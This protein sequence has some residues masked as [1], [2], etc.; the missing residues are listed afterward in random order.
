MAPTMPRLLFDFG[1]SLDM[2]RSLRP[3][4]VAEPGDTVLVPGGCVDF[5]RATVLAHLERAG[6]FS[7]RSVSVMPIPK[8]GFDVRDYSGRLVDPGNWSQNW[9]GRHED[10]V[11]LVLQL[12]KF[13]S[14]RESLIAEYGPRPETRC[15][16]GAFSGTFIASSYWDSLRFFRE[17]N[18]AAL[19]AVPATWEFGVAPALAPLCQYLRS[20]GLQ[21][22]VLQGVSRGDGSV[23]ISSITPWSGRAT[24]LH[25]V[26]RKLGLSDDSWSVHHLPLPKLSP[27]KR[28]SLMTLLPSW[29][30]EG[31]G[32][33]TPGGQLTLSWDF[34]QQ[35]VPNRIE[36]LVV[37]DEVNRQR[38][39]TA[40][41]D[42]HSP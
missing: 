29:R 18:T 25:L 3:L 24:Y 12:A 6:F 23:A 31:G 36:A 32:R 9:D 33:L 22:F 10:L 40:C 17:D 1:P 27:L 16:D 13:R 34:D 42:W 26:L 35:G 41:R 39:I 14:V 19:H 2:S 5:A 15:H 7:Y 4:L 38:L 30:S 20:R 28:H 21:V 8:R 11:Q 37:G